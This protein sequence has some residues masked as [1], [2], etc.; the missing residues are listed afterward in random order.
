MNPYRMMGR[1]ETATHL[2]ML[3]RGLQTKTAPP[4]FMA[5]LAGLAEYL[6]DNDGIF[7]RKMLDVYGECAQKAANSPTPALETAD[8]KEKGNTEAMYIFSKYPNRYDSELLRDHDFLADKQAD[9][10]AEK[11]QKRRF[12]TIVGALLVVAIVGITIYNLPYFQELRAF[13]KVETVYTDGY[14]WD[15][16]EAVDR[17]VADFPAGKHLDEVLI[18]PVHKFKEDKNEVFTL[19]DAINRYVTSCPNGQYVAECEAIYN[20]IWDKE[21]AA[22]QAKTG[23]DIDK[24]GPKFVVEMLRYMQKHHV[25]YVNVVGTPELNLKDYADFDAK[26]QQAMQLLC[27]LSNASKGILDPEVKIPD[28]LISLKN[29]LSEEKVKGWMSDIVEALNTGF[30]AILTPGF[31]KFVDEK[32][33]KYDRKAS[34]DIAVK[35]APVVDL[36]YVVSNEMEQFGIPSIWIFKE[37]AHITSKAELIFGIEIDFCADFKLPA[38]DKNLV[39]QG[40]GDSGEEEISTYGEATSCYTTMCT[41]ATSQFTAQIRQTLALPGEP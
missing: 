11:R 10:D 34:E 37:K 5:L 22:Y 13:H 4:S 40:H 7:C 29:N 23:A 19:L 41:R 3:N 28:D 1:I 35:D 2:L 33:A 32:T 39:I 25:R 15:L 6:N 36:K 26:S 12:L 8:E 16:P 9:D 17:Y 20:R 38:V 24:E 18:M 30:D 21:I 27:E 14:S 31:I